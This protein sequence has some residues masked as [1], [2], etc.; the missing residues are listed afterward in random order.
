M[1]DDGLVR[2]APAFILERSSQVGMLPDKG[3]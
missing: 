1:A 3:Q 2:R